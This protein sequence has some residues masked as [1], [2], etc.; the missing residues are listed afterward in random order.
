MSPLSLFAGPIISSF[1]SH[2]HWSLRN[3]LPSCVLL[4]T[5]WPRVSQTVPSESQGWGMETWIL[6][7]LTFLSLGLRFHI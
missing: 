5:S 6:L 7:P 2:T 4:G 1:G 3:Q